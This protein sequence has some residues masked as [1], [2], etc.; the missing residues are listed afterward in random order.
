MRTNN[1]YGEMIDEPYK[2]EHCKS[3][4]PCGTQA[5]KAGTLMNINKYSIN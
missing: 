4:H 5:T 1:P 3:T 2:C